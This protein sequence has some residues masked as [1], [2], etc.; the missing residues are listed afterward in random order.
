MTNL[1]SPLFRVQYRFLPPEEG[2]RAS[3]PKQGWRAAFQYEGEPLIPYEVWP[4][5]ETAN[6]EP[7]PELAPVPVEGTAQMYVLHEEEIGFHRRMAQPGTR[8]IF[9]EGNRP[10]GRATVT[11]NAPVIGVSEEEPLQSGVLHSPADGMLSQAIAETL[12][13]PAADRARVF[14][15]HVLGIEEF[16]V[17]HPEERPWTC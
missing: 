10:V 17:Q 13:T 5:F 7:L 4:V 15:Q 12:D 11:E 16:M 14:S 3:L 2:G 6:G 9:V 1:R 8:C